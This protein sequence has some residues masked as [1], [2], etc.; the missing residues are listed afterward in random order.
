MIRGRSHGLLRTVPPTRD[1]SR[2]EVR[3]W[4]SEELLRQGIV[5]EELQ[6]RGRGQGAGVARVAVVKAASYRQVFSEQ[7]YLILNPL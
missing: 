5:R 3:I 7:L 2:H 6:R 4:H 1:A